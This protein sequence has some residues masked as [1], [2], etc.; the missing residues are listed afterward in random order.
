MAF[1]SSLPEFRRGRTKEQGSKM[2]DFAAA[3]VHLQRAFDYLYGDDETSKQARE[4]LDL[5]IEAV[6]TVEHRRPKAEVLLHPAA[7]GQ[8]PRSRSR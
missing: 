3:R 2:S 4:A 8:G 7:N 6:A 1:I 5:L